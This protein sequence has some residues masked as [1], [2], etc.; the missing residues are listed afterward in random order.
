MKKL[1]SLAL[2]LAMLLCVGVSV[3]SAEEPIKLIWWTSTM[4]DAP[5]DAQK[6]VDAAN[7]I[8]AEKIGVVVDLQF[9]TSDQLVMDFDAGEYYDMV[10]TCD[11]Y[12]DFDT[13]AAEGLYYNVE[14]LLKE[15]AP[16]LYDAVDPWWKA[17]QLEVTMEDEDGEEIVVDGIWGIPAL[18]DLGIQVFFRLDQ[19]FYEG[20]MGWT[21]PE[22]M[23][24]ADLEKYLKAWKDVHPNEY[25]LHMTK[26]GLSGF[27]QEHQEIVGDYL[28]IPYIT[29]EPT[30]VI[31]IWEN[32]RYV[33]MVRCLH[34]WYEL[35][36]INPDAAINESLPMELRTPVRS[37]TAWNGYKGWSDPS[38]Y[39]F[40]VKLS[41]YI[42]PY[43]SRAS[44][45]G[46]LHAINAAATEEKAIA[47]LKYFELLY[48][49]TAFRD[50]LA[51]GIEGEHFTYASN[52]TVIRTALGSENYS[53]DTYVTGPV[54]SASVRSANETVLGDPNQ[55]DM[56]YEQ[57]EKAVI[58]PVSG[59]RYDK[60]D[61]ADLCTVLQDIYM[62][63]YSELCTGTL[64][65]D[66]YFAT[67]SAKMYE[68][69]LQDVIDDVQ[70]QLD[71][72]MAS[73]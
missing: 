45:Q 40:N 73:K 49:D 51:Y 44:M 37:G 33:N 66:E 58:A 17:A 41:Q 39:G 7:K 69:G 26:S 10:F 60:G 63:K 9:K 29:D 11:W 2:V 70:A 15:H 32:E 38:V 3:A 50:L 56:V 27:W 54:V 68:L 5:I 55:W 61:Y 34:K 18:K 47:A 64:D 4:G 46:A 62:E 43:M 71:E 48:T 8:S 13:N 22:T 23:E 36:Y 19:D 12:N 21:I 53:F 52:G 6:V 57:Y 16:A 35:G 42:G 65:P 59:F 72:Y 24:F 20:E 67:V 14:P 28:V 25:P 31:P 1:V 30:K